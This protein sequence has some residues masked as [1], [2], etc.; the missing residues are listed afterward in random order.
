M[1]MSPT[2]LTLREARAR[3]WLVEVV[4]RWNPY[5]SIRQDLF[6]IIDIVAVGDCGVLG[7]QATSRTNHSARLQKAMESENLQKWLE[8]GGKFEVWSWG[9][10]ERKGKERWCS[11]KGDRCGCVWVPRTTEIL[12]EDYAPKITDLD[13]QL[14]II[15]RKD[16]AADLESRA[17]E[18]RKMGAD[19]PLNRGSISCANSLCGNVAFEG[20]WFCSQPCRDDWLLRNA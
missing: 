7:I 9:K 17:S 5:A 18:E 13:R 14:G 3:G 16:L 10:R 6:G 19:D 8:G 20:Y 4:E 11:H 2:Q 15:N 12:Q 1:G